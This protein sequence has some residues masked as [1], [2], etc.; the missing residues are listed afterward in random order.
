MDNL[1]KGMSNV[2]AILLTT[3]EVSLQSLNLQHYK[4]FPTE[5]LCVL[6]GHAKKIIDEATKKAKGDNLG[7]LKKILDAILNKS[8]LGISDYHKALILIY[9]SLQQ[10]TSP[11]NH[12]LDLSYSNGD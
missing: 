9:N 3:P 5:P 4:V 2:P 6:K 8:T 10:C 11:N 12:M 1:Q 7:I